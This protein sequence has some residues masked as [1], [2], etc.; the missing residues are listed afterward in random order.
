MVID[1]EELRRKALGITK[2]KIK[3]SYSKDLMIINAINNVE[4][5]E[6]SINSMASRLRDWYMI[7][8]PELEKATPDNE[9]FVKVVLE[10]SSLETIEFSQMGASLDK[11]DDAAILSLALITQGLVETKVFLL[12]YL[13]KTM[14]EY[15]KNIHALAGTTIGAKLLRDAKSLKKLAS[16]QSSTIQLLGAEKALFRHIKTGAKSPK[17]GHIV[18]HPL[19]IN[20]KRDVR[21][22]AAR[23]LADKLSIAAR[24][25][26]FKGEFLADKLYSD[27]QQRFNH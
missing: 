1:F 23:A 5:L 2:D 10:Q 17:Y 16:L 12:L 7:K 22:K 21:G 6:R 20:A 19:I 13:E 25:D 18:N 11:N 9:H 27:L 14:K 3:N 8:N 15:C 26:Y 24:L 4:E